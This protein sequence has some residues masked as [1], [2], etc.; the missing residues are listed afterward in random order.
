[1]SLVVRG[2]TLDDAQSNWA[3]KRASG[4]AGGWKGELV[5]DKGEL[6]GK[7]TM[8]MTEM[9][10]RARIMARRRRHIPPITDDNFEEEWNKF[11][12]DLEAS[13]SEDYA[14]AEAKANTSIN[15]QK[16]KAGKGWVSP[17]GMQDLAALLD[18]D[19][20]KGKGG[21]SREDPAHAGMEEIGLLAG[22]GGDSI[23]R[24]LL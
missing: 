16:G 8:V 6:S 12:T 14:K 13:E 4:Q 11:E 22:N 23:R 21:G 17:D 15:Q 9:A 5:P 18:A 7:A 2:E 19:Q 10:R 1:M 3:R 24:W 20:P